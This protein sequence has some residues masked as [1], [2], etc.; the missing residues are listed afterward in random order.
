MAAISRHADLTSYSSFKLP[1]HATRLLKLTTLDQLQSEWV[2]R[3]DTLILGE[4]S[5]TVFLSDW[6]GTVVINQLKGVWHEPLG[7]GVLV[8]VAAGESWHPFVKYCLDRGWY[9][10]ENL[11]MIPG[12]VGAAPMQNIGAY[13]VELDTCVHTVTAWDRYEQTWCEFDRAACAFGY[14]DS[15]FKRGGKDRYIITEVAFHLRTTFHPQ[16]HYPSLNNALT[17]RLGHTDCDPKTLAATIMRLRRH[18]LPDPG[19]LANAGSFFQNPIVSSDTH[20]ALKAQWPELPSWRLDHA[21][22]DNAIGAPQFKLS[23]AWMIETAGL[24]G[25]RVGDAGVYRHHALVLVNFGHATAED[26]RQLIAEIKRAVKDCFGLTLAP[27]PRLVD[28]NTASAFDAP[29]S[30]A[31]PR[32]GSS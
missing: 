22:G 16:T 29:A 13:G 32:S 19:R 4:G 6:P 3:A 12:S 5:N 28:G 11:I 24:K 15:F 7:D 18:R 1:A 23:A 21:M 25:A 30:A 14:R 9:G 8:R 2:S 10:L 20:H 31:E 17:E 26:L 27:E